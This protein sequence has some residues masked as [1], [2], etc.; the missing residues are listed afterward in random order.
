[1]P[2][3]AEIRDAYLAAHAREAVRL[4]GADD[5][6]T[7]SLR[8]RALERFREAGFPGPKDEDWKYTSVASIFESEF[9]PQSE[10]TGG[11]AD[12]RIEASVSAIGARDD[13]SIAVIVNGRYSTEHSRIGDGFTVQSMRDALE[14]GGAAGSRHPLADATDTGLGGFAALNAAYANDGV[15]ILTGRAN[16]P[17]HLLYFA[18]GGDKPCTI[19]PRTTVVAA[20]GT[21]ATIVEHFMGDGS[22]PT[23]TNAVTNLYLEENSELEHVKVQRESADSF[24]VKRVAVLQEGASRYR[25]L[26]VAF[27]A[28]LSRTEISVELAGQGAECDLNG[29][30]LVDG[31]RH[32]D[33]HTFI[34]HAVPHTTSRELYKGVLDGRSRGVFTGRVLVRRDAQ[35]VSADQ[36]NR[37][38]ILNEGAV[39]DTRPQLEIYADDVRCS[40]GA[41]VGRLDEEALFYLRQRGLDSNEARRLLTYAFAS[42][43]IK[44]VGAKEVREMLD[45]EVHARLDAEGEAR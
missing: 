27:G 19:Q 42:D 22:A 8:S 43:V 33:H 32:A 14:Q 13:S 25:S 5:A 26:S 18:A 36:A 7:A 31:D 34:D 35:Q 23:L 41:T 2:S 16:A 10:T 39:A 3:A 45:A 21:S 1:M 29:L 9:G 24:H 4:P 30:Y 38:L 15:V 11:V 20:A 28:R 40:H 17:L 12:A 44:S 6:E 37:N